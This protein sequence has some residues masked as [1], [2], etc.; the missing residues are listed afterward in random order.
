LIW[1]RRPIVWSFPL[2]IVFRAQLLAHRRRGKEKERI[3]EGER[4]KE[5]EFVVKK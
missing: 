5:R 4:E 3:T 1:I 2:K